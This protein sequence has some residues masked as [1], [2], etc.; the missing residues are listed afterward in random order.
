MVPEYDWD[1][2]HYITR[3]WDERHSHRLFYQ[4]AAWRRLRRQVLEEFHYES[5]DELL[6]SPARYVRATCVHH[7]RFIDRYPGWALSE[8]WVDDAGVVRRN[9]VP[10]SHDAH[11]ARH[12]RTRYR[13]RR[14]VVELT[15]E[16]W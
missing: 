5:Q 13:Q 7:D 2:H 1:L 9:L 4:C 15:E 8:F 3:I 12:H 14:P 11:D 16:M 6:A 10:L